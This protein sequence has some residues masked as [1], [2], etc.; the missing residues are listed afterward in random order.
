MIFEAPR[1]DFLNPLPFFIIPLNDIWNFFGNK[2]KKSII[3]IRICFFLMQKVTKLT[4]I[5]AFFSPD[6]DKV[7]PK[8][9]KNGWKGGG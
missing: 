8:K 4:V 3:L 1:K 6:S 9:E 2:K 5:I 7:T